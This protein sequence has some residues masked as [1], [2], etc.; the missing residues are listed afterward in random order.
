MMNANN[1]KMLAQARGSSKKERRG[2]NKWSRLVGSPVERGRE[3]V[4][5]RG[6][7]V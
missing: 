5:G 6:S 2:T 4:K 7:Y 3:E 1:D